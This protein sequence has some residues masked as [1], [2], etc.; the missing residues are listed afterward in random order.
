ML[1]NPYLV[2]NDNCEQAFKFYEK[3]LGGKI[4][5]MTT[6]GETPGGEQQEPGFRDKIMH[7]R[8]EFGGNTL[9]ASDSPASYFEPTKGMSVALNVD[10]PEDAERIFEAFSEGAEIKMP[11][12][13]TFWAVRFGMLTDRFGTPWMINCEKKQ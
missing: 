7:A 8:M 11:L 10:S 1:C 2:F 3:V 13:E 6:F 9:M 5:A 4:I 12:Q